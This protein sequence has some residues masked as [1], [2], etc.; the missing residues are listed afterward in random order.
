MTVPR[1]TCHLSHGEKLQPNSGE[2]SATRTRGEVAAQEQ[3]RI[4]QSA[5]N[6]MTLPLR[7]PENRGH[8]TARENK[9]NRTDHG[10]FPGKN[11]MGRMHVIRRNHY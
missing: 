4:L 8:V 6:P 1:D 2:A 9:S 7:E 5:M 3:V 10:K 11:I